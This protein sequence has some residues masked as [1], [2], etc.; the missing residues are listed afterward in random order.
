MCSA[1]GPT[2]VQIPNPRPDIHINSPTFNQN[3]PRVDNKPTFTIPA[4][5]ASADQKPIMLCSRK[6]TSNNALLDLEALG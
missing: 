2:E 3:G 4:A 6:R 5:S 1:G